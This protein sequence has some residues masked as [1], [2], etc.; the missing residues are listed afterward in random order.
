MCRGESSAEDWWSMCVP[1]S[2]SG[3]KIGPGPSDNG[4]NQK[5]RE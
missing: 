4:Q 3:V 2:L 5:V 1:T